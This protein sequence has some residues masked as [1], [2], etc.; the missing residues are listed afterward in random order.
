MNGHGEEAQTG[1]EMGVVVPRRVVKE[2][3]ES[4]DCVEVLVHEIRKVGLIIDR[5]LGFQE[6]FIKLAA[7][8][9]TLGRAAA[10]LQLKKRTHIGNSFASV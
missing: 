8:L 10:E 9:E 6:E 3:D 7:P 4:C 1:F 5:V 2:G